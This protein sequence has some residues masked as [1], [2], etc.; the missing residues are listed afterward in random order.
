[1]RWIPKGMTVEDRRKAVGTMRAVATP[2]APIV[3]SNEGYALPVV[4]DVLDP[5]GETV[6]QAT[7]A[8]WMSP[9]PSRG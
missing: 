3:A 6:F 7:I 9:R 8:M 5:A 4:V 1:M 2:S